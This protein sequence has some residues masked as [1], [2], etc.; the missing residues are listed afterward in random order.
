MRIGGHVGIAKNVEVEARVGQAEGGGVG[1]GSECRCCCWVLLRWLR[2]AVLMVV[3]PLVL[4]CCCCCRR[5]RCWPHLAGRLELDELG[6]QT[7][8]GLAEDV[9]ALLGVAE[10]LLEVLYALVLALAV[11]PLRRSVLC[12]SALCVVR[13]AMQIR[14]SLSL[15]PL[16]P[17]QFSSLFPS[18]ARESVTK[19]RKNKQILTEST[20]GG[21]FLYR[22]S[23]FLF[24]GA[25]GA[26][27]EAS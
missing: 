7:L 27:G 9:V 1:K 22:F 8:V 12:S 14:A 20:D 23:R 19:T 3:V 11:G 4:V 25:F 6:V 2:L 16:F 21:A 18:R 26:V 5:C 10:H 17:L 13:L 15:S 24:A